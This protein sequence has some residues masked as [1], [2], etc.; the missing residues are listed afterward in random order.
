[1]KK[2]AADER[3]SR[4]LKNWMFE[5]SVRFG[6]ASSLFYPGRWS[7]RNKND[8]HSAHNKELRRDGLTTP[9]ALKKY[10]VFDSI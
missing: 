10:A 5:W 3:D 6:S 7:D 8:H 1:V 9:V 4:G 2:G